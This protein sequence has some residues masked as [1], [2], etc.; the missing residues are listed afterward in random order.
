M[1]K[2]SKAILAAIAL[3]L[4]IIAFKLPNPGGAPTF[5][6]FIALRDIKD[7][8]QRKEAQLRLMTN[9]PL[10][11][12]QGGQIDADVSGNVSIDN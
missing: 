4:C 6:D 11:R 5:G 8:E 3:A 2:I 12:V 10:V 9:L 7:P 1:D